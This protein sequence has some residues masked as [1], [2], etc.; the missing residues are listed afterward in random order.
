[1]TPAQLRLSRPLLATAAATAVL[2]LVTAPLGAERESAIPANPDA[3]TIVHVLD[4]LGYGPRPGDI[5]RVQHQGLAAYIDEQL[6]PEKIADAALN[7]QLDEYSTLKMSSREMAEKIFA[8]AMELRRD[9]Q[10]KQ[11]KAQAKANA[12]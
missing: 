6:H 11:Q 1:M 9:A 7:E 10:L 8:P 4:R 2:S 12:Q 3:R 5:E